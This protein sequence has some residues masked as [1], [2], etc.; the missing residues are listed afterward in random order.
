MNT[1]NETILSHTDLTFSAKKIRKLSEQFSRHGIVKIPN[2]VSEKLKKNIHNEIYG[3]LEKHA[4]RR[5]LLLK[6]TDNTPRYLSVVRSELIEEYSLLIKE[7]RENQALLEFLAKIT[8]EKLL[9]NVKEDEK[10]VITKQEFSGDTHGWHWGDYSFALIWIVEIPP[11]DCG[12]ML[13]CVPHTSWDKESPDL[14]Q[15]FCDNPIYTHS[16][17]PGD[18]YLLKADTTLHRTLPLRYDATRI[19][20]NMT[21]ASIRDEANPFLTV[22]DRWWDNVNAQAAHHV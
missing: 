15:Y 22:D 5:D 13:Q 19:M 6:T 21:W 3:L 18:V 17:V 7:V 10:F 9:T 12:G 20:L 11:V 2:I 16:F 8:Q 4:E 1:L 14:Y